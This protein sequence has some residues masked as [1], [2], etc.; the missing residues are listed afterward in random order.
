MSKNSFGI[1]NLAAVTVALGLVVYGFVLLL[2]DKKRDETDSEVIQRQLK[3]FAYLVLSQIILVMG[4]SL[5]VGMN[6]DTVKK[7]IRSSTL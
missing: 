2:Q 3:G 1:C 5:C 4:M 7:M 6:I